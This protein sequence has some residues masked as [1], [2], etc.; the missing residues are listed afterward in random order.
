MSAPPEIIGGVEWFTIRYPDGYE[1]E[2][3]QCA[4]CGGA[5]E[6]VTCWQC[7]GSGVDGHECGEDCCACID[8]EEN[9]PCGACD[10]RGGAWHCTES[11]EWCEAHPMEGRAHVASTALSSEAWRDVL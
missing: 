10:S 7:G 8:P 11:P 3:C 9:V 5:V 4:R 2:D 1:L 6:F